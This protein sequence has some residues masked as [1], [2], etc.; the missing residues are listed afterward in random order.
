MS[1]AFAPGILPSRRD[2]DDWV[3]GH[4]LP[5][6]PD[7]EP[8]PLAAF[9]WL[10][11]EWAM[12]IE[13]ASGR[14]RIPDGAFRRRLRSELTEARELFEDRGWLDD[15]AETRGHADFHRLSHTHKGLIRQ[16]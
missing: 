14:T 1:D 8:T 5:G 10:T 13:L 3:R 16:D 2:I 12:Q 11:D 7:V 6:L 4:T 9:K 15:P